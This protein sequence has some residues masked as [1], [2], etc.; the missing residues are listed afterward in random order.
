[1]LKMQTKITKC[2]GLVA[3][4]ILAGCQTSPDTVIKLPRGQYLVFASN[5]AKPHQAF[6][7]FTVGLDQANSRKANFIRLTS[8][9]GHELDPAISPDGL[10]LLYV[11]RPVILNAGSAIEVARQCESSL[12]LMDLSSG[13]RS[14]LYRASGVLAHP[15]WSPDGK[16]IAFGLMQTGAGE[17]LEHRV[18]WLNLSSR[19][20]HDLGTG[21]YP[22]WLGDSRHLVIS[23]ID[24]SGNSLLLRVDIE[25]RKQTVLSRLGPSTATL[26]PDERYL[27]V[28]VPEGSDG[29]PTIMV[30]P[31]DER[32][33]PRGKGVE[34]SFGTQSNAANLQPTWLNHSLEPAGIAEASSHLAYTQVV[35]N[36]QPSSTGFMARIMIVAPD[37]SGTR[38]IVPADAQNMLKGGYM[39]VLW[40]RR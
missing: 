27:A 8:E 40:L 19:E 18:K 34:V 28:A 36:P 35:F 4:L 6:D 38:E 23:E 33:Q 25:T 32:G 31:A 7:L 12:M 14:T 39:S 9:P 24:A 15:S 5:R 22:N 2:M 13:Q 37:G 16:R 26:S 3:V 10:H 1:M 29:R 11:A 17:L 20:V 30:Y 21:A